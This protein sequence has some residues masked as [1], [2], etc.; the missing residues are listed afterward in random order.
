M[1]MF[2]QIFKE[3]RQRLT[4]NKEINDPLAG[5]QHG[6]KGGKRESWKCS[7]QSHIDICLCFCLPPSTHQEVRSLG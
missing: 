5:S 6:I 1:K 7:K 4:L 2:P 3:I